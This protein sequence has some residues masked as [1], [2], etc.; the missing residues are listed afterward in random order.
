[1]TILSKEHKDIIATLVGIRNDVKRYEDVEYT[2][3]AQSDYGCIISEFNSEVY[4]LKVECSKLIPSTFRDGVDSDTDLESIKKRL[5]VIKGKV[6]PL[7]E[8]YLALADLLEPL[9]TEH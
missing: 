5:S 8:Q 6:G 4:A 7:H 9:I 3:A 1:M 2:A